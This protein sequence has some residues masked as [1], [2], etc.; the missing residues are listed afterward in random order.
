M[1]DQRMRMYSHGFNI[2]S[3]PD[4]SI[5]FLGLSSLS[6]LVGPL[7]DVTSGSKVGIG[8]T[9]PL[10]NTCSVQ[11]CDGFG[12]TELKVEWYSSMVLL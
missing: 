7:R 4:T 8:R 9:N 5:S 10:L 3:I 1:A 2:F 12:P 11:K 6:M